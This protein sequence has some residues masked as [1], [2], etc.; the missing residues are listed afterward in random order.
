M[1]TTTWSTGNAHANDADF[2]AW[3]SEFSAKLALCGLVQTADTGQIN[4]ATVTRP[5]V[6]VMAGYEIWRFNDTMQ[7]SAPIFLKFQFGTTTSATGP[8][9]RIE[10]GTGSDGA[11]TITG[12]GAGT[13]FPINEGDTVA[14]S[15]T[16]TPSYF[17]H[18][19]GSFGWLW[20]SG[21]GAQ[22]AGAI[23][24]TVDA[25]GTPT[26]VGCLAWCYGSTSATNGYNNNMR[27][28]RFASTP[29][30]PYSAVGTNLG[31]YLSFVPGWLGSTLTES[32]DK[33]VYIAWGSF[34]EMLPVTGM[35]VYLLSEFATATTFSVAMVGATAR[36]YLASGHCGSGGIVPYTTN[37]RMA[38]LWE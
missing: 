33:Q 28:I 14:G 38:F 27:M 34:P 15:S 17:C 5:A 12:I 35:A 21:N 11:G 20:K 36:T 26:A 10:I 7:A 22:G 6:N 31:M 25:T 8:G 16:P 29:S 32:G 37:Y 2:R 4:W 30:V 24:R 9:I 23:V 1:T 19:E 13:A 3:G 18:T